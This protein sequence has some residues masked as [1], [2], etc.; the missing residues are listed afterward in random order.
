MS[1]LSAGTKRIACWL[2]LDDTHQSLPPA[3][4][5]AQACPV[6]RHALATAARRQRAQPAQVAYTSADISTALP[7]AGRPSPLSQQPVHILAGSHLDTTTTTTTTSSSS[8][9]SSPDVQSRCV[10]A[11]L[12]AM[13]GNVL[14]AP[15]EHDRHW[16]VTRR[17]PQGLTDFW[18]WDTSQHPTSYGHYTG[19]WWCLLH[20]LLVLPAAAAVATIALCR[21][22]CCC[23]AC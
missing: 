5:A 13:C 6:P 11:M 15:V 8:S 14:G 3:A 23:C 17:F 2:P 9:S 7:A 4:P 21:C 12:G 16:M 18:R 1:A 10:G 20:G 19:G 22:Y